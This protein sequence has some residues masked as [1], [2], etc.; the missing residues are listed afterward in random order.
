MG[1][2]RA[3]FDVTGIDNR[4]Q[5]HYPFDFV[6][7]D[8]LAY[9]AEHGAEFDAVHASPPCND[10]SGSR[11]HPNARHHGTGW[12][13]E[14]TRAALVELGRPW[15]IE[16]VPGAPMRPDYQLC[17]CLFPG[18]LNL[19]RER[20]FETSWRGFALRAPCTHGAASVSVVAHSPGRWDRQRLAAAGMILPAGLK[21]TWSAA[22]GID[23]MTMR[24]MSQ[25]I[26]PAYTEY[27]GRLL[28]DTLTAPCRGGGLSSRA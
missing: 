4:P 15:I 11:T 20:W 12:V 3:G 9:L 8:A 16:N 19:R 28:L 6:Q 18:L 21:A 2:H 27:L 5:P 26:P 24:E 1:Y 22:M 17:G 14:A 23:W 10:H 13:L 25:A 7:A